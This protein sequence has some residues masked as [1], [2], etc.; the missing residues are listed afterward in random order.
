MTEVWVAY[1]QPSYDP[2]HIVGIYCTEAVARTFAEADAR[3]QRAWLTEFK[4]VPPLWDDEEPRTGRTTQLD[5]TDHYVAPFEV[6]C[7][8]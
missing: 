3:K 4:W 1:C 8:P 2:G 7:G 5:D 6:V